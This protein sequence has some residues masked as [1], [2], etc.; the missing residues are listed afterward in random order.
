MV[1]APCCDNMGVRRGPWTCEEDRILISHIEKYGHEN[2]RA[3]P[4]K[5][6]LFRCG[7][8]C[9]LRWANY[10]RPGI[11]RGNFSKEEE[12]TIISLHSLLG[13]RWSAIAA[14]LPG[15]TD[16][17]IKNLWHGH[18]KKRFDPKK[19]VKQ[20]SKQKN[21]R[22]YKANME[23]KEAKHGEHVNSPASF[24]N[25]DQD[26]TSTVINTVGGGNK[27]ETMYKNY[28]HFRFDESLWFE[29][30]QFMMDFSVNEISIT[31]ALNPM[32]FYNGESLNLWLNM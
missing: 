12:D 32:S 26:F 8:S 25:A 24:T 30:Q 18:L 13:T 19:N 17:E 7:K 29:P 27:S 23:F 4:K 9:R 6:G 14:K 3:I 2:W 16:N 10:L 28:Q 21:R 11:K 22:D 15:R 20:L 1:R 5:A 31:E